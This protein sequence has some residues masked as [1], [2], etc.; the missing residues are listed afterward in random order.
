M[1]KICIIVMTIVL[2][3]SLVGC[4][5]SSSIYIEPF[6]EPYRSGNIKELYL[7]FNAINKTNEDCLVE[8]SIIVNGKNEG[9]NFEHVI[10]NILAV[11]YANSTTGYAVMKYT[12]NGFNNKALQMYDEKLCQTIKVK[13]LK[14]IKASKRKDLIKYVDAG[15]QAQYQTIGVINLNAFNT[16]S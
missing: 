13:N 12:K 4:G 9:E 10:P 8:F 3:I 6:T 1:K 2:F 14:I 16:I 11:A 7:D 15:G 5:N